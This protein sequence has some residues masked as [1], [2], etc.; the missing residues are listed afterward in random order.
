MSKE[1]EDRIRRGNAILAS[2]QLV[3]ADHSHFDAG[4]KALFI[5]GF[6]ANAKYMVDLMTQFEGGGYRTFAYEYAS[7]RG[8]DHAAATLRCLL[9]LLDENH[10]ISDHRFVVVAHSMGGLVAR[11]FV[12]L[13][14]GAKYVRKVLTL[15]TPHGGTLKN[16]WLLRA[17][18]DWGEYVSGIMPKAYSPECESAK[19]LLGHDAPIPLLT[20]L[21]APLPTGT[22][23]DFRSISGAFNTL[24]FG[25]NRLK[26][27]LMNKLMQKYLTEPNDG[28]V[29]ESSS[30]L[31]QP[32]FSACAPGCEHVNNYPEYEDINHTYLVNNHSIAL[33]AMKLA[34]A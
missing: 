11:A 5:H 30:N 6:T 20:R 21:Q 28:L 24:E 13:E 9:E 22:N 32:V 26:N 2:P 14:G 19:Q 31:A 34:A 10:N 3:R 17:W 25:R 7:Y 23:V 16:A 4:K 12:A 33:L 8:I 15:G 27:A 18:L 29:D 1:Q